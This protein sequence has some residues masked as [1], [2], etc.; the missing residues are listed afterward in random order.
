MIFLD[1]RKELA[2]Q[3][4]VNQGESDTDT[5]L[6]RWLNMSQR[7]I[8]GIYPWPFL[9]AS[10]PLI[11]QTV[12]D[13]TTGTVAT[14]V[15]SATITFS[16]APTTSLTNYY[17][18]TDSSLDWYRITSHTAAS[19]TATID[20]V[21]IY[22]ATADGFTARKIYYSLTSAVDRILE[23]KQFITPYK[24]NEITKEMF[25][26]M[27]PIMN[28][29]GNPTNYIVFGK[30]SSDIWQIGFWPNPSIRENVQVEYLQ[31]VTDLSGDND[32]SIIPAKWH[33]TAMIQGAKMFG[34]DW[35]DDSRSTE[36]KTMF[37]KM[38]DDMEKE[39]MPSKGL[40]R[41]FRSIDQAPYLSEFPYPSNYPYGV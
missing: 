33:T 2:S 9:R 29:T 25:D 5:R 32:V 36:A 11:I 4:G 16:S 34:F 12:P 17:I 40:A 7:L 15:D 18:Q 39:A 23:V 1:Q 20:P 6:K 8:S 38:I 10:N 37:Y 30:D 22:T 31:A 41:R 35:L 14:A 19:T 24:L 3:L 26:S 27:Q 13:L 28:T 21:A